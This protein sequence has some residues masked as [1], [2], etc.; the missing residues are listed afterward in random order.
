VRRAS[1]RNV[2][3]WTFMGNTRMHQVLREKGN[4]LSHVGIFTF[5]VSADGT[6]SE[7]GTAVSAILPYVKKW[8]HIKWLLTIMN[9]GTASIFTA[10]RENTNGAQDTFISEIVRIIDKYPWCSGIDIDLERGGELANRTKANVL[11][12][13]IYSTV[14]AKGANLHVNICLPGMTSVG[15]S[16]GGENWC[17]YADLDAYCDTAAIMSYGMSWAG[18]A[19]GPVSPRSWLEGIYSYAAN[20][21]NPDKIMMGLPGYGWRW[22]IYDTTE[23]LGTTYRGTSLTYYAAKYWMEGLYNHTGDAPPQPFIPFFSYWDWTD[24]VP[25]G[26]LHVYDF[27]EGW[28]TSRETAEP[29]KH[30]TYSGR[31]YLTT[32]LKQQKVS[33]GAISVDRNGVPDSYSGNAVIGEGY[34]SVLDEEAV[35]KYTFEVPTA[36]TYDVAV[37]I[38]YPRWDKNSIG[39]SLDGDSQMLSESR[40]YFL[41]WRKKFWRILKSG[42]SLSAGK[43]TIT[44]SGGVPGVVFYGFRV[45][46][47]FS[48]K[49][50]AG[51]VYYGLKPRKFMNVTG[52]MVQPD[53]AFKVTAEVLRRKPESALVWYEDFCDYSEIPTN[54]FT[55][56]DGSWKIWKDESSDRVRKYS[57]LEGSGKLALDYAGFSEIHVRARFAFKSSGGGKAGVFLGSIFCCINYDTQCV[58]L[59]QGSKKLG[60]YTSSFSKTSNADLRSDP[61]LYTV[62]MRIRGNMVRVY[63]GAAYTL[64]FTATIT[65]ETGYVGFMAEKGVVCDLLRLGDAWYYEPYECFDITFPDGRQT[66]FGRCT[67][68]GISWDNEFELF[69]VNSDVE[70][71][72]TRSQDISMDYDFFHS[73]EMSLE[74]G[75]D[76]EMKVVPHDLN[77]W[78]SRM[79]LGDAD[80]FSIMYYSDVDSIVYWANEAAY[81]YGVSGIA[82]WSLG[83]EDMRLWDSMPNQI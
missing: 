52:E 34:A 9:H 23:N 82:I 83:Q 58:E 77:V 51:E 32:Y 15:G 10:L 78:L 57:Q 74:C 5:E 25:W 71:I 20:A 44:V 70:E 61:S 6:I 67:R 36:G 16:V 24:M 48:Q 40:L 37:E 21:M 63:S 64:R 79:Y 35:L 59:Y 50:T 80:G 54:Y 30:E 47:D 56:L 14:K 46:S 72:S 39:I 1:N 81:T 7:T 12:S 33:F 53:R 3:A 45:C 22:Q 27:M 19:P 38:V 26:L 66:T 18:S 43:H 55:V 13:R 76:Y 75:N 41:Y 29:T 2:M 62:E 42:V 73:H 65:A 49:A 17:V 68:T 11:F 69:R 31:K 4:K 28:D 8:P 60:S